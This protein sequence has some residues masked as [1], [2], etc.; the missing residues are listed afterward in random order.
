[1]EDIWESLLGRTFFLTFC[2]LQVL[3]CNRYSV[4]KMKIWMTKTALHFNAFNISLKR[5]IF[6]QPLI[7]FLIR[8]FFLLG[9]Q[10]I[11]WHYSAWTFCNVICDKMGTFTWIM[12]LICIW[13]FFTVRVFSDTIYINPYRQVALCVDYFVHVLK[14]VCVKLMLDSCW[15][16]RNINTVQEPRWIDQDFCVGASF[17]LLFFLHFFKNLQILV[18]SYWGMDSG[19]INH[20]VFSLRI[21]C[22]RILKLAGDME[23]N[24]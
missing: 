21:L 9:T 17:I 19:I 5:R 20:K 6:I 15:I 13:F 1:M 3:L 24:E 8:I 11:T 12:I 2:C 23:K 10:I 16:Y 14:P 18:S 4:S 7:C 22:I